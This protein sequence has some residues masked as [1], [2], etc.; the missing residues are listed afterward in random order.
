MNFFMKLWMPTPVYGKRMTRM[1]S[2]KRSPMTATTNARRISWYCGMREID[3]GIFAAQS[4]KTTD[5][6]RDEL[7][8]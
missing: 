8:T 6:M 5:T 1:N 4:T 2:A 7:E 3:K